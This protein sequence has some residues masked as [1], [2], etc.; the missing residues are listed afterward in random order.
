MGLT[1][2]LVSNVGTTPSSII[3]YMGS[4]FLSEPEFALLQNCNINCICFIGLSGELNEIVHCS[5]HLLETQETCFL[6]LL[7]HQLNTFPSL[8]ASK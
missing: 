5:G 2:V 6:F 4:I 7:D 1:H 8:L 3:C